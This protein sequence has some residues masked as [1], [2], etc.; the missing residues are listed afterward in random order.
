MPSTSGDLI[1]DLGVVI[2]TAALV[3][4]LFYQLRI[5]G[6]I[7]YILTGVLLGPHLF[8]RPLIGDTSTVQQLGQLGVVFLFF[9]IGM[10][11]D[12][13]RL[14]RLAAPALM[15]L[16][17]QAIGLILF[18]ILFGPIW[19]WDP[20]DCLFF[21]C[22]LTVSSSM[23][24]IRVLR[25]Q[26]RLD[27]PHG[28]LALAVLL[29]EDILALVMLVVLTGASITGVLEGGV[30]WLI[31]FG[32][33]VFI[34]M[35]FIVGRIVTPGI[36]NLLDRIGDIELI[37]LY[38]VGFVLAVSILAQEFHFSVALGAF[39]AGSVIS[40]SNLV[41][42]IER[43]TLPLRDIFGALFFVSIG[44]LVDPA[45]I[46]E[47]WGWILLLALI[48]ITVKVLSCWNGMF[49]MGQS[50]R[51]SFRAAVAKCQI[52]EFSF[53]I[54]YLGASLK[55]TDKSFTT[56][57]VSVAVITI[58]ATPLLNQ[59]SDD[60]FSYI[61]RRTPDR[62]LLIA[63]FYR[64]LIEAI[65]EAIRS[66]TLLRILKRPMIQN[67]IYFILINGII[68]IAYLTANYVD[69]EASL[70][71]NLWIQGCI[72]LLAALAVVPIL[73]ALV[74]NLNAVVVILTEAALKQIT[75]NQKLR[76]RMRKVLNA[77]V[78]FIVHMLVAG[79]FL[80]AAARYFPS[81]LA[82]ILFLA[83]LLVSGLLFWRRINRLQSRLE[84][85][86]LKSFD[87]SLQS[88][89]DERRHSILQ[90][91]SDKYPWPVK[92]REVT[93]AKG[94]VASG[95]R[96]IDLELRE[97]TGCSIIALSRG[98]EQLIDPAPEVALFS[99]DRLV[100]LGDETQQG[101]VERLLKSPAP[102]E[103]RIQVE[104][105]EVDRV[106]LRTDSPLVGNTLAGADLRRRHGITVVGIQRGAER[107]VAP[108]PN[109]L[110]DPDDVLFVVG[111]RR[112][113]EA[114]SRDS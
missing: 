101:N 103:R 59:R 61:L 79:I 65:L 57:A 86:F 52:G 67:L 94:T 31:T 49:L 34:L 91:I 56:V 111:S 48:V 33:G 66:Y 4:I 50:S 42:A 54:A 93:I 80:A 16:A 83:F 110:M 105:F 22:L 82:L 8:S 88:R 10:D 89:D 53:V 75:T 25:D 18:A 41:E 1:F 15:S 63:R 107:I 47:T 85:M 106:Y 23:V 20:L 5:P 45:L 98:D 97:K 7:G 114:F 35:L 11:F 60:L 102:A 77:A 2:A 87:Q 84:Y 36:L 28:Q 108:S 78:M 44:M 100:I 64:K 62:A 71:R 92:L 9:S 27:H 3:S 17:L 29:L 24:T 43:S 113:I 14:Q 69:L 19:E 68:I 104:G 99:G 39:L 26:G 37:T 51:N 72:W 38:S 112:A 109:E 6:I 40:Q 76:G 70:K 96:I 32:F 74:R 58:L 73:V 12:L 30:E 55:A 81:G 21:G 13:R 46:L 90:E 95:R